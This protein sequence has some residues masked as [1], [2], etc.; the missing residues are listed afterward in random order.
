MSLELY[1]EVV[2]DGFEVE[3]FK[4][5]FG[6]KLLFLHTVE[7]YANLVLDAKFPHIYLCEIYCEQHLYCIHL[8]IYVRFRIF[9]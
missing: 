5:N 6:A 3:I 9:I 4:R 2:V 1:F 7:N 8:Q